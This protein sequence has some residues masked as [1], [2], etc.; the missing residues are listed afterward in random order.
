MAVAAS[1]I[2][3]GDF[4]ASVLDPRRQRQFDIAARQS[5]RV[6]F[7]RVALP[8]SGIA[9]FISLVLI[10]IITR[11]EISIRVGDV[12]ITADGLSMA[13]PHLSGSDGSGRTYDV[14]AGGAMQDIANPKIIRLS[15]IDARVTQANGEQAVFHAASGIFDVGGQTLVLD[16]SITIRSSNGTSA[17]LAR[18]EIDLKTGA[19]LSDAPVAFSSTLGAIKADGMAV[20]K[21]KG[22]VTFEGGVKMVVDPDAVKTGDVPFS[23]DNSQS[24]RP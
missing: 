10:G 3:S 18:A 6:R 21:G 23:A 5:R 2:A 19:V 16:K 11:I 14:T 20:D 24:P 8:A 1:T 4:A 9:L 7:L 15:D 22:S 17:D 13:A 12:T